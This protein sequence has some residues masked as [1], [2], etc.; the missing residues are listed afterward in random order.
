MSIWKIISRS[1]SVPECCSCCSHIS[2]SFQR[3]R[4][5]AESEAT[6]C[7]LFTRLR[8]AVRWAICT[9][10]CRHFSNTACLPAH[11]QFEAML[12]QRRFEIQQ[13]PALVHSRVWGRCTGERRRQVMWKRAH[14]LRAFFCS[15]KHSRRRT[16]PDVVQALI[17]SPKVVIMQVL[18]VLMRRRRRV[19]A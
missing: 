7:V 18:G 15:V 14:T 10:A 1:L 9:H 19:G 16:A 3:H 4:H 5:R 2:I 17:L 12:A 13:S 11:T 8:L 6:L